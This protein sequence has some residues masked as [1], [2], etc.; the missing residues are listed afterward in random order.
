MITD[1]H[2]CGGCGGPL[3]DDCTV[4]DCVF[5]DA[6]QNVLGH[7]FYA[8]LSLLVDPPPP[9]TDELREWCAKLDDYAKRRK[10]WQSIVSRA[11][12]KAQRGYGPIDGRNREWQMLMNERNRW[13]REKNIYRGNNDDREDTGRE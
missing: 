8:A 6:E 9:R 2:R 7:E 4:A 12:W 3:P 11:K 1:H 13:E 5:C 10:I